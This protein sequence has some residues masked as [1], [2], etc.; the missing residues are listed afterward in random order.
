MSSFLTQT[1]HSEASSLG[2]LTKKRLS[3]LTQFFS[4]STPF[5]FPSPASSPLPH[6]H[7]CSIKCSRS[8]FSKL[9]AVEWFPST[10]PICLTL[11]ENSAGGGR[12]GTLGSW[13]LVLPL[14]YATSVYDTGGLLLSVCPNWNDC[15]NLNNHFNWLSLSVCPHWFVSND[16]HLLCSES[17]NHFKQ[18]WTK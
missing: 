15:L 10:C 16:Y 3:S 8:F 14:A 4:T 7:P 6:S 9:L 5:P 2:I 1:L 12:N 17:G 11:A 18:T 13:C